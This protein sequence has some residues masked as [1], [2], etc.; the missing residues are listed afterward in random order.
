MT[1]T[2]WRWPA[3]AR[4]PDSRPTWPSVDYAATASLVSHGFVIAVVPR[5]AWPA[6]TRAWP[7]CRCTPPC[8]ASRLTSSLPSGNESNL[9][10]R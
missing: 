7:G 6:D 3:H 4:V 8:E 10:F 5:L 1:R 2:G 9:S